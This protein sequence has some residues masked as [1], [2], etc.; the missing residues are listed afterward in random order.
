M[1]PYIL[2]FLFCVAFCI[3]NFFVVEKYKKILEITILFVLIIFSGTRYGIGGSDY[4]VYKIAY[5]SVPEISILFKYILEIPSNFNPFGFESGYTVFA[6][7]VK[8]VGLNFYGFT[9]IHSLLFYTLFYIGLKKY[10]LHFNFLIIIFMYKIFFYN[11]FI[12]MRQSITIAIFFVAIKFIIEKKIFKYM[13]S[14]FIASLFHKASIL[15]F[16]IYFVNKIKVTMK[17]VV[18]INLLFIPTI[19]LSFTNIKFFSFIEN[20]VPDDNSGKIS[21][22]FLNDQVSSVSIF[23]SFE[24]FLVMILLIIFLYNKKND[25]LS[26]EN[27]VIIMLFLVL[28]PIFTIFRN[29]EILTRFKDYFTMSYG[30]IILYF[31]K[32]QKLNIKFFIISLSIIICFLGYMRFLVL[33]DDGGL[34]PYRSYIFYDEK[35]TND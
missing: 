20:L 27:E 10:A 6:S 23:H 32:D 1:L 28:I 4:I 30:F 33:F 21:T 31:I 12:S 15:L 11:T 8:S 34:M 22:Y 25:N 26:K 7:L 24:Y 3:I 13:L 29:Y 2:I 9:L 16:L 14:I 19:L 17:L 18:F 35:I 5:N